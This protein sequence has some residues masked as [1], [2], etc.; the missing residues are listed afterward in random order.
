MSLKAK[1]WEAGTW[2]ALLRVT[3]WPLDSPVQTHIEVSVPQS[4]TAA[5][6]KQS[7]G[8]EEWL[9]QGR[10]SP[11]IVSL[12][13]RPEAPATGLTPSAFQVLMALGMKGARCSGTHWNPVGPSMGRHGARCD[14]AYTSRSKCAI[15]MSVLG[16]SALDPHIL[17]WPLCEELRLRG[18]FPSWA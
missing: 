2:R 8:H 10:V 18:A 9:V 1:H 13:G 17:W 14:F 7:P 3:P 6:R 5:A 15:C 4:T 11:S 12:T 16:E